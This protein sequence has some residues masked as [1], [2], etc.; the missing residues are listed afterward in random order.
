LQELPGVFGPANGIFAGAANLKHAKVIDISAI[1]AKASKPRT[2][3]IGDYANSAMQV[4]A[5]PNICS[6]ATS[7]TMW[8]RN[9]HVAFHQQQFHHSQSH[10]PA[11]LGLRT[12]FTFRERAVL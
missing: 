11:F 3:A 5:D 4:A 9:A 2:F 8:G 12:F 7:S 6:V 10:G 1:F